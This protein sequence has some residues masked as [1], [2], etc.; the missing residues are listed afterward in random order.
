MEL[1]ATLL[2]IRDLPDAVLLATLSKAAWIYAD[3]A[4]N[5]IQ[6]SHDKG[7]DAF[8]SQGV[9]AAFTCR[10]LVY[11]CMFLGNMTHK[12]AQEPDLLSVLLVRKEMR[13]ALGYGIGLDDAGEGLQGRPADTFQGKEMQVFDMHNDEDMGSK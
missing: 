11:A 13:C 9:N 6:S 2:K 1:A 10:A 5:Q 8:C 7:I 3:S 12:L 4:L